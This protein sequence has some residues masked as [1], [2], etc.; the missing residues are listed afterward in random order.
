MS[1][2]INVSICTAN[3]VRADL[4]PPYI[5]NAIRTVVGADIGAGI[6]QIKHGLYVVFER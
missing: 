5:N 2:E 1:G 4:D 3:N 6:E